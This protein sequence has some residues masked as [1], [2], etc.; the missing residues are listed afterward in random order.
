MKHVSPSTKRQPMRGRVPLM[1]PRVPFSPSLDSLTAL[2]GVPMAVPPIRASPRTQRPPTA[3]GLEEKQLNLLDAVQV[4]RR[5]PSLIRNLSSLR[6]EVSTCSLSS[7]PAAPPSPS[8]DLPELK[9]GRYDALDAHRSCRNSLVLS[10]W[11]KFVS[12]GSRSVGTADER[13][14]SEGSRLGLELWRGQ[15]QVHRV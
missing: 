11:R 6:G 10:I 12:A 9:H 14:L 4:T 8:L 3:R 5:E 2:E 1:P 13:R 7:L 15:G